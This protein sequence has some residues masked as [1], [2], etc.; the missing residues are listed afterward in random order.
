MLILETYFC[1]FLASK[2]SKKKILTN[3]YSSD[4]MSICGLHGDARCDGL[5]TSWG[6]GGGGGGGDILLPFQPPVLTTHILVIT[7]IQRIKEHALDSVQS[8]YRLKKRA[9]NS[10]YMYVMKLSKLGTHSKESRSCSD[11]SPLWIWHYGLFK[12]NNE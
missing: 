2:T 3:Q 8:A 6:G 7:C 9:C 5:Y 12:N 10:A 1:V 11:C 4:M